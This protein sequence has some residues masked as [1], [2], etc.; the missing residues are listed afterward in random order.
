MTYGGQATLKKGAHAEDHAAVYSNQHKTK[1]PTVLKKEKMTKKAIKIEIM[2]PSDK[3][4]PLSRINYAKVY[5]VEH[6]VKVLFIGQVARHYE[7][8]VVLD[9]NDTHGPIPNRPS[10][11]DARISGEEARGD[12]T[13][14]AEGPDPTYQEYQDTQSLTGEY[15]TS[16]PLASQSD[17]EATWGA[18]S[19]RYGPVVA[20]SSI[21]AP[22]VSN[23]PLVSDGST[24][25][26]PP[27]QDPSL[28]DAN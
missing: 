5:T 24:Q 14:N 25:Y 11:S 1:G 21:A 28:Y 2:N 17:T 10:Y 20:T 3:L 6:N 7:Q 26:S 15:T 18:S 13:R 16:P 4:D 12:E 23:Y 9:Y 22:L 19:S 27:P 8:Q